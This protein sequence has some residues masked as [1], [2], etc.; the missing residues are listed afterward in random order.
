M[1]DERLTEFNAINKNDKLTKK[2]TSWSERKKLLEIKFPNA[3]ST[4]WRKLFSQDVGMMGKLV[5]DIL[6]ADP[7]DSNRPGKRPSLDTKEAS[8]RFRKVFGGDYTIEPFAEAF[9]TLANGKSI[10]HISRNVGLDKSMVHGL[11]RGEIEP[12]MEIIEKIAK[13][14]NK[15]PSYFVEYRVGYILGMLS[16][17]LYSSPESSVVF[18]KKMKSSVR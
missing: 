2:K 6:K 4:D 1:I 14:F 8:D 11:L 5:N 17:K 15:H 3:V 9:S 12:R 18:Y 7:V 16:E 10:R 13:G